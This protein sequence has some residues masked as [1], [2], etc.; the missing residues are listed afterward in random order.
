MP[1]HPSAASLSSMLKKERLPVILFAASCL[2]GGLWSGL[3]RIG[4]HLGVTPVVAHHGAIMVGGF[5]G[6]LISFEKVI[7][8]KKKVLYLIP[9]ASAC[10]VILFFAGMPILAF[11]LMTIASAALTL[12]FAYYLIKQKK[13]VYV[14][15][16]LG[17]I[18]WLAGNLVLLSTQ[19]YPMAFRWWTAFVLFIIAAER[20]ELM[21]FRPV[22]QASKKVFVLVLLCFIAGLLLPFHSPGNV[23]C[24]FS[25]AGAST[26][27]LRNDMIAINLKKTGLP[28]FIGVTLLSGYIALLLTG[29]LFLL[30]SDHWLTY[31]AVVHTFFLGFA[32]SMIFAHGPMILPGILGVTSTPYHKVLYLW[33]AFLQTSWI[34]R[35]SGDVLSNIEIRKVSG[36]L[37]V[38]AIL[39]YFM[40]MA[41]LTKRNLNAS[42]H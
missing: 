7:P 38:V 5:L 1:L 12:V 37:S 27:L 19:F 13:I 29:I 25:L 4:W 34:M 26:W 22:S 8:L 36:L 42:I 14:L 23:V 30:R 40:T 35:I 11:Y 33:T 21:V 20:L 17:A 16:L 2:L 18:F 9:I 3:C 24:G 10:S 39:G 15:M 28:L 32:F 31:D 6:S 41:I